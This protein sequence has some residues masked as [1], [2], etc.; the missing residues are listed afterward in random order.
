MI[1][2]VRYR[3]T[4]IATPNMIR[5]AEQHAQALESEWQ[6]TEQILLGI[7]HFPKCSCEHSQVIY[8]QNLED[9]QSGFWCVNC[10]KKV[11]P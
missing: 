6:K 3:Y 9:T 10:R 7:Q 8:C 1:T 5:H 4:L 2:I 11:L